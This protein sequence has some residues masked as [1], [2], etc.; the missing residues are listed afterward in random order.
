V[1]PRIVTPELSQLAFFLFGN[2]PGNLSNI[3]TRVKEIRE[4]GGF[5]EKYKMAGDF[6]IWA[7]ISRKH[8]I[9]LS[10]TQ[11]TFVRRHEGTATNYLN[12]KGL[13]FQEQTTIYEALI[14]RLATSGGFDRKLLIDY[15]NIEICSAH[16]RESLRILL[17]NGRLKYFRS[18]LSVESGVFWPKW[19]RLF[20]SFPYAVNERMRMDVLVKM[21]NEMILAA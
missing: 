5:D 11:A 7:R 15:F 1:L 4:G 6:E 20:V 18:Y 2:F 14:D 12:K 21:A 17:Y 19:K 3:S 16:L 9:V 13:M 8:A 10:D